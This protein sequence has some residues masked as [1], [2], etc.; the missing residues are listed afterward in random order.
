M[1]NIYKILI[2]ISF[3]LSLYVARN[4]IKLVFN[5]VSTNLVS[6]SSKSPLAKILEKELSPIVKKVE[7]P[8][9]LR[10]VGDYIN[11]NV[12]LSKNNIIKLTNKYRKEN[13]ELIELVENSKLDSSAQNKL[14]DMF[15]GQYFEHVSPKGKG[16]GDLGTEAGYEYILIGENLALGDFKD[17]LA[18][19]DAWMAS[20]GHRANILNTHYTEIGVAVAKGMYEGRNV[21]ISVQHFGT[22]RSICPTIDQTLHGLIDINKLRIKGM[23]DDFTIRR[24]NLDL[25]SIFEGDTYSEQINKYNNLINVYNSLIT[26]TKQK[27]DLFN[28]QVIAFN[29]CLT[30]NE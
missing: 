1:K 16:V 11:G 25:K 17:D 30:N 24:A 5:N 15:S 23:E 10:V 18:L 8:G 27:V 22:P 29:L 7:M 26:D 13:G 19:V 9:P 12:K 14:K 20:P 3:L 6:S 28:S 2:I 4:D 21:W